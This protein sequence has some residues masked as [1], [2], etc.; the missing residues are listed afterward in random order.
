VI[1]TPAPAGT[2]VF[3]TDV[4]VDSDAVL[5]RANGGRSDSVVGR[6]AWD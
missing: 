1:T 6:R 4:T 5:P 3:H 2:G